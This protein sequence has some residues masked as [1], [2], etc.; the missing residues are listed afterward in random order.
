MATDKSKD[1]LNNSKVDL[2]D[3]SNLTRPF[4]ESVYGRKDKEDDVGLTPAGRESLESQ[5]FFYD[6][7]RDGRNEDVILH[8]LAL[9]SSRIFMDF[10]GGHSIS[11]DEGKAI[12]RGIAEANAVVLEFLE[13]KTVLVRNSTPTVNNTSKDAGPSSRFASASMAALSLPT[14]APMLYKDRHDRSSNNSEMFYREIYAPWANSG[15]NRPY[16]RKLDPSLVIALENAFRGR[17][18][19]F[20]ALLPRKK[21]ETSDRLKATLGYVPEGTE[22]REALTK[23]SKG[24]PPSS[25]K[26]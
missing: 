1:R 13:H 9:A 4:H 19:E 15:L 8:M 3:I 23:M 10:S 18:A 7:Y 24:L 20:D 17:A 16:L 22:R 12:A 2:L 11:S 14:V 25:K 5:K 21:S 26:R 6:I